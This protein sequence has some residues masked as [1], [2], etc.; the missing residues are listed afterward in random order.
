MDPCGKSDRR[1][2]PL[3]FPALPDL[4]H[5]V[6]GVQQLV[7][8]LAAGLSKVV[9]VDLV[10]LRVLMGLAQDALVVVEIERG[11][12]HCGDILQCPVGEAVRRR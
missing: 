1:M 7:G 11:C 9:R 8:L 5:D 12:P 3:S 6:A 10:Q 4:P 2:V